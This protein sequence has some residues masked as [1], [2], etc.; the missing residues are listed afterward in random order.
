MAPALSGPFLSYRGTYFML[1]P[2]SIILPRW[3]NWQR[4]R[5]VIGRLGV[6]IPSG[7]LYSGALI[8]YIRERQRSG[9]ADQKLGGVGERLKPPDCKSGALWASQVRILPP[10]PPTWIASANQSCPSSSAVEHVLGKNG[11]GGSIPPLGSTTN[12]KHSL[13]QSFPVRRTTQRPVGN[14]NKEQGVTPHHG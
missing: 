6:Q 7:A 5:F 3:R 13:T 12:H 14:K 10:P 9:T 1:L 2:R 4:S 8:N 11:V